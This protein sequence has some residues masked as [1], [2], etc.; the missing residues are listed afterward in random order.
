MQYTRGGVG[1]VFLIETV[2]KTRKRNYYICLL[3]Y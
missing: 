2:E 1:K 3:L